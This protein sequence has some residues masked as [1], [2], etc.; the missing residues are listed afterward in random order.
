MLF[1]AWK[2]IVFLFCFLKN[3]CLFS[4]VEG[5]IMVVHSLSGWNQEKVII[6]INLK[7]GELNKN[8]SQITWIG[9]LQFFSGEFLILS[10]MQKS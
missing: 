8:L 5:R 10:S 7:G 2:K 4:R 1:F 6:E 9:H 3:V